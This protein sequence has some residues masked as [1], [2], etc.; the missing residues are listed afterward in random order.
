MNLTSLTKLVEESCLLTA[1]QRVYWL[2]ELPRM[3]PEKQSQLA[4]ILKDTDTLPFQKTIEAYLKNLGK[5]PGFT[6]A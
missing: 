6:A 4:E 2:Q 5:I 1:E 3:K